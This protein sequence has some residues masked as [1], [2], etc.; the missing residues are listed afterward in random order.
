M[1]VT[2][3]ADADTVYGLL[4]D[5]ATWPTWSPLG[6]FELLREGDAGGQSV[7]AVRVFHTGRV[8]SVERIVEAVP[9]R[10]HSYVLERGLPL[11]DYRAD[12]DLSPG[13]DGTVIRWRSTFGPKIPGTGWVY[14]RGLGR[15]IER[16][17]H[18]LA[19]R[20][21]ELAADQSGGRAMP[22]RNA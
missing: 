6:S 4:A 2:T 13:P 12:I 3:A 7:G 18:G 14:R 16:T 10:R 1:T 21:A 9:G 19:A 5:G 15:F 22:A 8:H 17:V 20:A 11:R